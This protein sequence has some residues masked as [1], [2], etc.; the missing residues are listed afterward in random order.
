MTMDGFSQNK[1]GLQ[2]DDSSSCSPSRRLLLGLVPVAIVCFL[3]L[4]SQHDALGSDRSL[5]SSLPVDVAAEL[6]DVLLASSREI[7]H[8]QNPWA[9]SSRRSRSDLLV[10]VPGCGGTYREVAGP[11]SHLRLRYVLWKH[12]TVVESTRGRH[13]VDVVVGSTQ[14]PSRLDKALEGVCAGE[15]LA[16]SSSDG[17][18]I[19][20]SILRVQR[21]SHNNDSDMDLEDALA[22][23]LMV[24]PGIRGHSCG[25]VC[26]AAGFTCSDAGFKVVNTCPRL[27]SVFPCTACEVAAVGTSGADMPCYV[28]PNAPLGHPRGFCM[29]HPEARR[30]T[31]DASYKH[32]RRLCPCLKI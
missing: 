19:T 3:I 2:I 26:S 9:G 24:V 27:R 1:T 4:V 12:G 17:T 32:T 14:V 8:I 30:S 18:R 21:A 11:G 5:S 23:S 6:G 7:Y 25:R 20:A 16:V 22:R 28:S 13:P 10:A 29:V 15:T 31:C